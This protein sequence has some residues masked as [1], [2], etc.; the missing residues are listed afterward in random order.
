MTDHRTWAEIDLSAV[1]ANLSLIRKGL[2]PETRILVVL[3]ADAY[4]HGAVPVARAALA[5]GA[6]MLG[7]ATPRRPWSSA[8]PGSRPP[9]SS[10]APSWTVRWSR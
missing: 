3:K 2:P 1:G 10:W 4:G 6:H 8:R 9:S 5:H 7:S